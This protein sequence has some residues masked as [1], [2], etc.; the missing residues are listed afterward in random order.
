MS[1]FANQRKNEE[2]FVEETILP[3]ELQSYALRFLAKRS[4]R[5]TQNVGQPTSRIKR[6]KSV[7]HTRQ[8][9]NA[10]YPSYFSIPTPITSSTS[11]MMYINTQRNWIHQRD[12]KFKE[13]TRD[14]GS[15][16]CTCWYNPAMEVAEDSSNST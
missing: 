2:P 7:L 14:R 1:L 11:P 12:D 9:R 6:N 13:A 16:G 8:E 15:N 4:L 3:P 5:F 10:I